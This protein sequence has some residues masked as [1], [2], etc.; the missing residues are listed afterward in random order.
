ML[1]HTDR[2]THTY[3]CTCREFALVREVV[4]SSNTHTHSQTQKQ[5]HI[6]QHTWRRTRARTHTHPPTSTHTHTHTHIYLYSRTRTC[7]H[8]RAPITTSSRNAISWIECE[9]MCLTPTYSHTHTPTYSHTQEWAHKTHKNELIRMGSWNSEEWSDKN[10]SFRPHKTSFRPHE[11]SSSIHPEKTSFRH[12]ALIRPRLSFCAHKTHKN[13]L[14]RPHF[15]LLRPRLQFA[16]KRPHFIISPWKDLISSF[17]PHET[18]SYISLTHVNESC[19]TNEW[20][21]S[22]KW[23][24]HVTQMNETCHTNEWVMSQ[25]N[26]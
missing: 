18:S 2:H 20:V 4:W 16:L 9:M 24:S 1:T 14:I 12:F 17:R 7:T 11:T 5:T 3:T 15:A 26:E 10:G 23:M 6:H 25:T 13:E 21:M 19:H 22:H 8:A